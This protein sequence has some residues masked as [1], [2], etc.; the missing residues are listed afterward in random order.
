MSNREQEFQ[1]QH[2]VQHAM[3]QF[4]R[5]VA[6]GV[7]VPLDRFRNAI[8]VGDLVLYDPPIPTV[9]QVESIEPVL[10]P[11]QPAGMICLA[12]TV[13]LPIYIPVMQATGNLIKVGHVPTGEEAGSD[14]QGTG[15]AT[16]AIPAGDQPMSDQPP[17]ATGEASAVATAPSTAPSTSGPELVIRRIPDDEEP[18]T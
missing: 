4:A 1:R 14:G 16:P 10:D 11:R 3:A 12:V 2:A 13:K 17:A 6:S 8:T 15:A 18:P 9:F 5:D 7:A